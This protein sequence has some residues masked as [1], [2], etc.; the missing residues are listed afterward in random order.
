MAG[1]DVL[2]AAAYQAGL[3]GQA[4][5]MAVAIGLGESGGNPRAHNPNPPDDSYGLWQINMLGSMGPARRRQFGISSNSQ[6]YD[7]VINAR[8]MFAISSGGSNWRPWTVYTSG[9]Y[10]AHLGEATNAANTVTR[11]GGGIGALLIPLGAYAS[12]GGG[13][14]GGGGGYGGAGQDLGYIS[15]GTD[16]DRA[17]SLYGYLGWFVDHPE[18]G[19][20]ILRAARE[21]WDQARLQG[22][23]AGTHWW[24]ATSESA[25]QWDALRGMDPATAE[26]RVDETALS[27]AM[28]AGKFGVVIVQ[29]R[30]AQLAVKA[31]RFGWN[32]AEIQLAIAA[33]MR[34]NPKAVYTG[35]VGTMISDVKKSAT[36]WLIPITD[37]QAWD[38]AH[39]MV[40]GA[41]TMDAVEA[42]FSRLA[43]AR[44]PH[45]GRIVD[46]GIKLSD[47]FQPQRQAISSLL[48][49]PVDQVNFLGK[50]WSPVLAF[51]PDAK[52]PTRAMTVT[53]AERFARMQPAWRNTNNAWASIT[54]TGDA[55]AKM[56]GAL[57]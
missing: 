13:G 19:P 1:A 38:W 47:Y 44:F 24:Q 35:A 50:G 31:L 26:R 22:A 55:V 48:E 10:R 25:R 49:V 29:P 53:E 46:Q 39:R 40:A 56:F 23:L 5:I 17:K 36:S 51:K 16:A 15:Q 32:P 11:R 43:K 18:V 6:L 33:E 28:Q 30:L 37:R 14:G 12:G 20:I 21:G 8:A 27:I 52:S 2:A 7:P 4:L 3:R 45:L 57:A 54:E 9:R 34:Y 41:G 42:Q